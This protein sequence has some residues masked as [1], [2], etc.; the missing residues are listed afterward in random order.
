M[1]FLDS[2]RN[3]VKK[4]KVKKTTDWLNLETKDFVEYKVD[5]VKGDEIVPFEIISG[6][7]NNLIYL[8]E[9][10]FVF[11]IVN[12][13]EG[14]IC[15]A[16][17]VINK[18]KMLVQPQ[19]PLPYVKYIP[20]LKKVLYNEIVPKS[21]YRDYILKRDEYKCQLC[22]FDDIRALQVHH[23]VQ[24]LN[25]FIGE[26]FIDSPM[27]LITLCA[28]CH[29]IQHKILDDGSKSERKESVKKMFDINGVNLEWN[30]IKGDMWFPST[31]TA[32]KWSK[33]E[34]E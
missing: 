11:S 6:K 15:F 28:N 7:S 10:D 30:V 26:D 4:S 17:R 31:D 22:G 19:A 3:I 29:R 8:Q 20:N 14:K 25:P 23:I 9:E 34:F 27:N 16:P 2:E 32:S 5:K 33:F 18:K 12:V 1:I 21:N 13:D 24:R